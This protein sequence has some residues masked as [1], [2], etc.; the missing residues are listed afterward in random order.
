[1]EKAQVFLGNNPSVATQLELVSITFTAKL[2]SISI[3]VGRCV[4]IRCSSNFHG[5]KS[6]AFVC[7]LVQNDAVLN[8]YIIGPELNR[9]AVCFEKLVQFLPLLFSSHIQ[10]INRVHGFPFGVPGGSR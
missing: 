4:R 7:P 3:S 10:E 9:G 6:R 1:M 2:G 8:H 5:E